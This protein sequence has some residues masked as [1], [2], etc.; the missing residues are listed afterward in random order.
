MTCKTLLACR[1]ALRFPSGT[2]TA[3]VIRT[4]F[5]I[6]PDADPA[7]VADAEHVP[8]EAVATP[9][10]VRTRPLRGAL[11]AVHQPGTR[12]AS[13]ALDSL[14]GTPR[15]KLSRRCSRAED[16]PYLDLR[17]AAS[18]ARADTSMTLATA[19]LGSEADLTKNTT[20]MAGP[21]R[22]L[23]LSFLAGSGYTLL[24]AAVPRLHS[25]PVLSWVGLPAATAWGWQLTPSTG[26]IGQAC[27]PASPVPVDAPLYKGALQ[28]MD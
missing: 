12:R 23:L 17:S 24:A 16:I 15:E 18:L 27:R 6:P 10:P 26:Y 3:N 11:A 14:P 25:F 21:W 13:G 8:G 5:G 19:R 4:L 7:A 2:A 9:Q 28:G 20:D 1:E 22:T